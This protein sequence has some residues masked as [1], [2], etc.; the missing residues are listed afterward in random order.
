MA[1]SRFFRRSGSLE[2]EAIDLAEDA[3][4]DTTAP[5]EGYIGRSLKY[6]GGGN[7]AA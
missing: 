3:S 5:L 7:F 2:A 1:V 4:M 6:F